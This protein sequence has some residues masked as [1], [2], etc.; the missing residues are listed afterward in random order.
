M[1]ISYKMS[2]AKW[3]KPMLVFLVIGFSCC[4]SWLIISSV[5]RR[6]KDRTTHLK[7][8]LSKGL[9]LSK[10]N[11]VVTF[12]NVLLISKSGNRFEIKSRRVPINGSE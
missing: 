8:T 11:K 12:A 5:W 3:E 4:L 2:T 1:W 10:S 9:T 7:K 6:G